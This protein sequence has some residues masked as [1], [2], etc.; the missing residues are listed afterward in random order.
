MHTPAEFRGQLKD[1]LLHRKGRYSKLEI[2][3]RIKGT[4]EEVNIHW[5]DRRFGGS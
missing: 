4:Q 2:K 5:L 3:Q 1:T